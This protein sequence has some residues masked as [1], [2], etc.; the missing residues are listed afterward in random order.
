[1]ANRLK[2]RKATTEKKDAK[3]LKTEIQVTKLKKKKQKNKKQL[4]H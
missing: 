4:M 1:M 3:V 2:R